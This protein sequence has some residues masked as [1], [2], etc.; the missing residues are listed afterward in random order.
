MA[1]IQAKKEDI[2]RINGMID[3]DEKANG[4]F[5]EGGVMDEWIKEAL[6]ITNRLHESWVGFTE[7]MA[8]TAANFCAIPNDKNMGMN[9][10]VFIRVWY[11]FLKSWGRTRDLLR[12]QKSSSPAFTETC[13]DAHF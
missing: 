3:D 6:Q 2:A 4:P 1:V 9:G 7:D 13:Q 5:A 12:K 8:Q 11:D 10:M